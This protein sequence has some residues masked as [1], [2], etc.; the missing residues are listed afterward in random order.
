MANTPIS[1]PA[2]TTGNQYNIFDGAVN[3]TAENLKSWVDAATISGLDATN[4]AS[5]SIDGTADTPSM[6]TLGTGAHQACGGADTRLSLLDS[7][8]GLS[9]A[10]SLKFGTGAAIPLTTPPSIVGQVLMYDGTNFYGASVSGGSGGTAYVKQA[11]SI[12]VSAGGDTIV[13]TNTQFGLLSIGQYIE[14]SNGVHSEY[15]VIQTITDDTHMTVSTVA[16]STPP[17]FTYSYV[18]ATPSNIYAYAIPATRPWNNLIPVN[19]TTSP[20]SVQTTQ[21][22]SLVTCDTS[23]GD[24]FLILPQTSQIKVNT[25][26]VVKSTNDANSVTILPYGST[27]VAGEVTDYGNDTISGVIQ[28]SAYQT[29]LLSGG[30]C[31]TLLSDGVSNWNVVAQATVLPANST[32]QKSVVQRVRV[33]AGTISNG[34]ISNILPQS[35]PASGKYLNWGIP[36]VFTDSYQYISGKITPLSGGSIIDIEGAILGACDGHRYVTA[37]IFASCANSSGWVTGTGTASTTAKAGTITL[38]GTG[39]SALKP[40]WLIRVTSGKINETQVIAQIIS[41]TSILCAN[42]FVNTLVGASWS[43]QVPTYSLI[44]TTGY[45]AVNYQLFSIPI[46]AQLNQTTLPGWVAGATVSVAIGIGVNAGKFFPCATYQGTGL[47]GGN[48]KSWMILEE[49]V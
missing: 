4:V 3:V 20:F 49:L 32:S 48:V 17:N 33:T 38:T 29:Q 18:A 43:Y 2:V 31:I 22:G 41:D 9:T 14:V 36:P 27:V 34:Y 11:G 28:S 21:N 8:T 15:A 44:T 47:Y 42:N 6:R 37:G 26:A 13:G 30:S 35:T 24:V 19:S 46:R 25:V 5:G 45:D 23:A 12:D 7:T 40:G 39:F 1:T 16:P 10:G